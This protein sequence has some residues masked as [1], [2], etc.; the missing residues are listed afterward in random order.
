MCSFEELHEAL[1][2]VGYVAVLI[3]IPMMLLKSNLAFSCSFDWSTC[4]QKF[5]G[6]ILGQGLRSHSFLHIV[7]WI[8]DE[9]RVLGNIEERVCLIY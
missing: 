8:T 7:R 6:D 2:A 5:I 4:E 9:I 3:N 1:G